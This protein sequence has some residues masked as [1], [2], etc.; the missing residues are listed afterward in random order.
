MI[1]SLKLGCFH[2]SIMSW[3][4]I[5]RNVIKQGGLKE[6][7]R[8]FLP[9]S[10]R[11]K[12]E[13]RVSQTLNKFKIKKLSSLV[14]MPKK[15][16]RLILCWVQKQQI[17]M[18]NLQLNLNRR[19]KTLK[20]NKENIKQTTSTT[21]WVNNCQT[22]N[23]K[24]NRLIKKITRLPLR[25]E[26]VAQISLWLSNPIVWVKAKVSFWHMILILSRW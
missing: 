12:L 3:S 24:A 23:Q 20:L 21:V 4:S 26:S 9:I 22:V 8:R 16:K 11:R 2:R 13:I 7:G 5:L 1:S 6:R 25:I 14:H 18:L 15:L 17:K 10:R 19:P